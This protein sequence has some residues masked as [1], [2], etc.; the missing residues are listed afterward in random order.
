MTDTRYRFRGSVRPQPG[1]RAS[2]LK[3]DVADGVATMRLYDPI[4]SWGGDWG[5]SAKEFADALGTLPANTTEIRLHINSPGGMV[6]EAIAILNQ[7]R[8]H[9]ARVVAVVDGLAA[10]AASFI[11]A[12]A[13]EVVMGRNTEMMVHDAWNFA[14]GNAADMRKA[15]D[16]LDQ[17]SNNIA[18]IYAAKAGNDTAAWRDVMLAETWFSADEA[19][20]AGLADSVDTGEAADE[21]AAARFDLS[22][23]AHAG[24]DQAPPPPAPLLDR[25]GPLAPAARAVNDGPPE[26]VVPQNPPAEPVDSSTTPNQEGADAMSDTLIKGLRERL[27]VPADQELTEAQALAAVDEALAERAGDGPAK[28]TFTPPPG[29]VVLDSAQ[30]EELKANGEAGVQARAEQLKASREAIVDAAVADGRI[31]PARKDHWLAQ[32]AADEEGIAPVLA[33]LPKGTI[34][35]VAKGVTGGVDESSDEDSFYSRAWG[36]PQATNSEES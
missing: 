18:S 24:R 1:T 31:P 16:D 10:S 20:A 11:A 26:R 35:L 30:Y 33:S 19:V 22:I 15:A 6:Y 29:T 25:G 7:L 34:P 8:A 3:A 32:L 28:A 2:A 4:D 9:K 14:I 21:Q 17:I 12:G 5:V 36:A 23:F 27:G 13:D